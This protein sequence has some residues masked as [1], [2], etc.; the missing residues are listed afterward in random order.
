MP[1]GSKAASLPCCRYRPVRENKPETLDPAENLRQ[2]AFLFRTVKCPSFRIWQNQDS[3]ILGRF[4]KADHEVRMKQAAMLGV[5]VLHRNSG[6]GAV[7]HDRGNINYSIYLPSAGLSTGIEQSLRELSF[8]VIRLLEALGLKWSWDPPNNVLVDGAKISGS[9]QARSAGRVLHHGTLLVSTDLARM[10]LLLKP[11]GRSRIVPVANLSDIDS[12]IT[13]GH[14]TA[15][16]HGILAGS[17]RT[18]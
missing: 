14:A 17:V 8:P 10:K 12:T 15:I 9:A 1:A 16:F 4:L 18:L 7:F 13:V 5:P 3:V 2:E 6:G 11:G